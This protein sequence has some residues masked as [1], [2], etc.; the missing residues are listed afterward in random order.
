MR[1]SQVADIVAR[2]LGVAP[3]RV[4]NLTARLADAGLVG[5]TE[6]SRRFPPDLAEHEVVAMVLAVITDT[7][8]GDVVRNVEFFAALRGP[9]G[10]F[11]AVLADLLFGP[12]GTVR[13]VIIRHK[14]PGVSMVVD[15][16]HSEFGV[17][18]PDVGSADARVISGAAIAAIAAEL[19]GLSVGQADAVAAAS[20]IISG[21]PV[22]T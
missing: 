19:R 7:G 2:R 9:A 10:R 4:A 22:W 8:L 12:P 20:R 21:G 15:G 5:K 17:P 6:G 16:D 14:P 18:A 11:D 13:H 3:S 1:K